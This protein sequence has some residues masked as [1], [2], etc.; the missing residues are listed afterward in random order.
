MIKAEGK[1]KLKALFF[2]L[3]DFNGASS[4][5]RVYQ[6]LPFLREAGIDYSVYPFY[7]ANFERASAKLGRCSGYLSRIFNKTYLYWKYLVRFF[8]ILNAGKYD[9]VF[10]QKELIPGPLLNLLIRRNAKLIFDFDDAIYLS[11]EEQ[12]KIF[13]RVMLKGTKEKIDRL[14]SLSRKVIVGNDF[15]G[16]YAKRYCASVVKIPIAIDTYRYPFRWKEPG[17]DI[18]LGWIGRERNVGYL[19]RLENVFKKLAELSVECQ[20]LVIGVQRKKI[21]IE[22]LPLRSLPWSYETEIETLSGIDIGLMPLADDDWSRGKGGCKLLQ[23]MAL[24]I[25]TVSSPV[26]INADIIQDGINGFMAST[27]EDWVEKLLLLAR[28]GGL[29]GRM[30]KNARETIEKEFSLDRWSRIFINN[31]KEAA[32]A[33]AG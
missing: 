14:L 33:N 16:A 4:R 30:G 29:R 12:R 7:T 13:G 8:Q 9:F 19:E 10:I 6:Y 28:D 26:G 2:T 31:I 25:P 1:N 15:I 27:A 11:E 3:Y 20:L 5:F 18:V 23:Y 22:S 32:G 24:G 17:K 21:N